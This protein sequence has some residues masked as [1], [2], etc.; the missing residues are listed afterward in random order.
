M[1]ALPRCELSLVE[2][3][4]HIKVVSSLKHEIDRSAELAG[5]D[6]QG[7]ALAVLAHQPVVMFLAPIIALQEEAGDLREGPLQMHIS[8]FGV[9]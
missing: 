4:V 1:H 8:D 5:K 6:R 3:L 7:F 9:A 2:E